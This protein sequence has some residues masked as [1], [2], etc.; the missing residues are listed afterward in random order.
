MHINCAC[1]RARVPGLFQIVSGV[2]T[3]RQTRKPASE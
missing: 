3:V 1:N 2:K